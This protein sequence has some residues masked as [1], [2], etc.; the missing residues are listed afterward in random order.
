MEYAI[1]QYNVHIEINN[2]VVSVTLFT[3]DRLVISGKLYTWI[4]SSG[5]EGEIL[6]EDIIHVS[7][8]KTRSFS[9]Y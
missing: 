6:G 5:K 2:R 8:I 9:L 1:H 7:R 3:T 4:D